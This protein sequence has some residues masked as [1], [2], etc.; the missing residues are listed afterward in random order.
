MRY[1][2]LT[3]SISLALGLS[4]NAQGIF[5]RR[6]PRWQTVGV[7]ALAAR[8][9]TCKANRSVYI[10]NGAGCGGNGEYHY[11]TATDTWSVA[12]AAGT[13]NSGTDNQVA[14]FSGAGTTLDDCDSTFTDDGTNVV[15]Q[16]GT[17][18]TTGIQFLDAD[19]GTPILNIDTTNER[20]GIGTASPLVPLQIEGNI[21]HINNAFAEFALGPTRT[22]NR[23]H[24][25]NDENVGLVGGKNVW[26]GIDSDND[27]T[28][29]TFGIVINDNFLSGA[30]TPIFEVTEAGDVD[31]TRALSIGEDILANLGTPANG[32]FFYCTDCLKG[33][34]PCTSSSTGAMGVRVNGAWQCL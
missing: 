1:W 21:V 24:I 8:P 13:I 23:L 29:A 6:D 5:G 30:E 28:D 15:L 16:P 12:V 9:A 25:E 4:L 14:C 32:T 26:I 33:S 20:V 10:C 34:D 17:D 18:S 22:S 11:C 7:G 27:G 19:G 31:V 3:L 2:F